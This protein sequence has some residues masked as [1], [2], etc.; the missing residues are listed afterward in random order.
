[1]D[2]SSKVKN[3]YWDATFNAGDVL[4]FGPETRG[5][6]AEVLAD[7]QALTIPI[8]N[9]APVR[10][11]NLSS[12]CSIV[13]FEALKHWNNAILSTGC[14]AHEYFLILSPTGSTQHQYYLLKPLI[15]K[16]YLLCI[17]FRHSKQHVHSS[18]PS[19]K[20]LHLIHQVIH[21]FCG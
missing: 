6:S 20:N 13:T 14:T 2:S 11:L 1:V 5:L 9:D 4:V 18:K 3:S 10:S 12:A 17:N 8:R 15:Y 19:I 16:H 7:L 21:S